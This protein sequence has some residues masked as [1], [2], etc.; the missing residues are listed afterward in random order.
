MAMRRR[1]GSIA[2]ETMQDADAAMELYRSV[3]SQAPKDLEAMEKLAAL[4]EK[5]EHFAELLSLRQHELAH[6]DPD[7]DR[8]LFLRLEISRLVAEVEKRGGRVHALKKNLEEQPGHPETIQALVAVLDRDKHYE[9]LAEVLTQQATQLESLNRGDE[10]ASLWERVAIVSETH[11]DLIEDAIKAYRRVVALAA[12]PRSLDALA[13][14]SM[15][16]KE[17]EEAVK[18][19]TQRLE[20]ATQEDKPAVYLKLAKAHLADGAKGDAIKIMEQAYEDE[21]SGPE[22]R[23]L[24]ITSYR[25][26][27][28]WAPL[29]EL[30]VN[31]LPEFSDKDTVVAHAREAAEIFNTR[32]SAPDKAVPALEKAI[33]LVPEDRQMRMHLASGLRVIGRL[34][35]ARELLEKIIEEFGRRRSAERAEAHVELANVAK[36]QDKVDEALEQLDLA[37]KMAVGNA[38]IMRRVADAAREAGKIEKAEKAYRA[39][40]LVVR[41]QKTGDDEDAV[42]PSEVLYELHRI[43]L[44]KEKEEDQAKDL[45]DS[46]ME[47]AAASDVEVHRLRRTL[48]KSGEGETLL[49]ALEKRLENAENDESRVLL[50]TDIAKLLE[51][52]LERPAEA[53]GPRLQAF[54]LSPAEKKLARAARRA[55]EA[56]D[57]LQKYVECVTDV[58]NKLRRKKEAPLAADLLMDAGEVLESKLDSTAK[59]IALYKKAEATGHR[60]GDA[61]FALAR[62]A[63][64]T[65]DKEEQNRAFEA[66][67]ELATQGEPSPD[68]ADALY[69]LT[70][71]QVDSPEHRS[72]AIE[73]LKRALDQEPRYKQAAS[74]LRRAAEAD[75]QNTEILEVYAPVAKASNDPQILLDFLE[76]RAALP[77][78]TPDQVKE[79]VDLALE[80]E[81]PER[82][83]TLYA[84]AVK[85]ARESEEGLTGAVW[86]VLGLIG[87][88]KVSGDL[89]GAY[90]LLGEISEV[91]EKEKLYEVA[92]DLAQSAME[93]EEPDLELASALFEFLR[94]MNP[95][96]KQI[97]GPLYDIYRKLDEPEHLAD[98]V[99]E[100]LPA[101]EDVSHRNELRLKHADYLIET[102]DLPLAVNILRDALMDDPQNL[103]A[104]K[105]MET[106]FV[107]A[108][109]EQGL[110]E[111]LIQQFEGA[112]ESENKELIVELTPKL[113]NL[114]EKL[115]SPD[116]M[117]VFL[118]GL[119][120][121]P[122]DPNIIMGVLERLD[123]DSEEEEV[124]TR[125]VTLMENYLAHTEDEEQALSVAKKLVALREESEDEATLR[126]SYE[127][128]HKACPSQEEFTQKLKSFYAEHELLTPLA[129]MY[130]EDAGRLEDDEASVAMYRKAAQLYLEN[131][132]DLQSAAAVLKKAR[133][134]KPAD[135]L[136]VSELA[137]VLAEAGD[138]NGAVEV[139]TKACDEDLEGANRAPSA[140]PAGRATVLSER[141][142]RSHLRPR[143]GQ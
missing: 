82:A 124:Q 81:Q 90:E 20:A 89:R 36:A 71:L 88:K 44:Q 7:E 68:Q 105:L 28:R 23:D 55:A 115:E 137:S 27:K 135:P 30:L 78:V 142:R 65:G 112:R 2:D 26:E 97:W 130:D 95:T 86:A 92:M 46:A 51:E 140:A 16:R 119:E 91:A 3:L 35:E 10:A 15:E 40:L 32:L 138:A 79:A 11:L 66:L 54:G 121:A 133:D 127:L 129:K 21:A 33:A 67:Q 61:L 73:L 57:E 24:L 131:L 100:L 132:E 4:Y 83:E 38:K 56:H 42:G 12:S 39:L 60:Q 128:A 118:I 93:A 114:L 84:R 107:K 45:L 14:L 13:R 126:K 102:E 6:L 76:R 117:N 64:E 53:V 87:R 5:T 103:Q 125:R 52:V 41:R 31:T 143:G 134:R 43:A 110:A 18:W 70:E 1:A 113:G 69:R 8:R 49:K 106:A 59:A 136:L 99:G 111:F 77:G 85:A 75:P 37:S 108:D 58:V 22:L 122:D 48:L 29:A 72:K 9:E 139:L 47:A 50:F 141:G 63:G 19:L 123:A 94:K 104:T 74:I 25:E 116:A 109:D 62:A 96:E 17:P 98:L 101:L 34:D 120:I 80:Q